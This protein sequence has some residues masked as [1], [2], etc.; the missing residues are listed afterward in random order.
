MN[1]EIFERRRQQVRAVQLAQCCRG[2]RLF[3]TIVYS[4]EIGLKI[5]CAP[6]K[7]MPALATT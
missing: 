1:I 4:M 2:W 5:H 7:A 3:A 6:S